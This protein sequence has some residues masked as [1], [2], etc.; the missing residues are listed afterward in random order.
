MILGEFRQVVVYVEHDSHRDN[1]QDR[2][3]VCAYKL[4]DDV[5]VHAL[6]IPEWVQEPEYTQEGQLLCEPLCDVY[7]PSKVLSEPSFGFIEPAMFS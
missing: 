6:D 7:E 4:L 3:E 1:Q 2:E 5:P